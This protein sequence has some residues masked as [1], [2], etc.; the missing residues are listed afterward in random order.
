MELRKK[1]YNALLWSFIDR[2]GE[3]FIRFIFSI[4]L[5]R[6]L[7]PEHFGL[8]GIAYLV[9]EIARVFV[10][11][12]FGLAL[13]NKSDATKIDECSVFYFNIIIGIFATLVIFFVSPLI[14]NFYKSPSLI[15]ILKV[16]SLNVIIGSFGAI[17]TVLMT[18]RI[19]FKAQT[20][21]S[22]PATVFSGL[23]G[24]LFA[25]HNFGVWALVIQTLSRTI[26]NTIFLWFVHSWRPSF[27]FSIASLKS[28]FNFGSRILLNSVVGMIFGNI[29]TILIGKIYSTT[30]LGYYTRASQ[31]QKLPLDTIWAIIGR[32]SFPIFSSIKNDNSKVKRIFSEAT[33]NISFFVFPSL[34]IGSIVSEPLFRILFGEKWIP[35]VP[36]FQILCFSNILYPLEQ[37]R[38][39]VIL[40]K[41][42]ASLNLKL[43]FIKNISI[44]LSIVATSHLGLNAMLISF[45]IVSFLYFIVVSFFIKREIDYKISSQ[46]LDLFPYGFFSLIAGLAVFF[47]SKTSLNNEIVFLMIQISTGLSVYLAISFLFKLEALKT[48][49]DLIYSLISN[50]FIAYK[51]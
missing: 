2:G 49:A 10:Q 14:G 11:S 1:T 48:N 4:I 15:P 23:I 42:K 34:V 51:K 43:Q 25:Y 31:T 17:Q 35:S 46:F 18:K 6:L 7:L 8:I 47:V 20:K 3:Q 30:Q 39:N 37:L 33:A 32:V 5:A 13:I 22:L 19:D 38:N 27:L 12:G 36:I 29:H 16:L 40:A 41:G 50:S 24:I 26:L 45:G 28:M 21:V 44:L 9:T